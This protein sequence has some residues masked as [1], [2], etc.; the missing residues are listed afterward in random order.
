MFCS[1]SCVKDSMEKFHKYECLLFT[2]N[3]LPVDAMTSF[4]NSAMRFLLETMDTAQ[5]A[6]RVRELLTQEPPTLF[7]FDLS[8][9][10]D[11][12][13]DWNRLR[14]VNGLLPAT[15]SESIERF[16]EVVEKTVDDASMMLPI[17]T[18]DLEVFSEYLLRMMLIFDRNN[19]GLQIGNG[20]FC[21]STVDLFSS[22]LNHSCVPNTSAVSFGAKKV[23]FVIK[24]IK[25]NEQIFISYR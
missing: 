2:M 15:D 20:S 17:P 12:N 24:P 25:K 23:Q 19:Q 18:N 4:Y 8:K 10:F 13:F 16:K 3:S 7:D 5:S 21:A 11:E 1:E 22:L 6:V 14:T 9:S